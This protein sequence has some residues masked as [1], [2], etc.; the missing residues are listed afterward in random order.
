MRLQSLALALILGVAVN[1][2]AQ[3]VGRGQT[4]HDTH[5]RMCHDSLVYTRKDRV[6]NSWEQV[7]VEVLRW[8]KVVSLDWSDAD[9]DE[10]TNFIATKYYG[11]DCPA[12]C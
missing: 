4:L 10:V 2:Y 1:A 8:Q 6:A 11:L 5:C 7:R 12:K 9:I 3:D